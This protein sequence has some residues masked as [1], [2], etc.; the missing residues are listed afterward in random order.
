MAIR[1][2]DMQVMVPKLQQVANMRHAEN[3][4]GAVAQSQT[5]NVTKHQAQMSQ[6]TVVKSNENDK[7]HNQADAKEEG[8]NKYAYSNPTKHKEEKD[9][10]VEK[11]ASYHKIDISI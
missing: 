9:K 7:S 1:P 10:V 4:K 3:Q 5:A 8:K 11:P 6:Q 2:L